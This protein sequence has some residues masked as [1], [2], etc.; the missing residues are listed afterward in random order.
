M[1]FKFAAALAALTLTT[2][3]WAGTAGAQ[4]F[5]DFM[6][7]CGSTDVDATAVRKAAEGLGWIALPDS[8]VKTFKPDADADTP[9]VPVFMMAAPGDEVG[10]LAYATAAMPLGE[11]TFPAETCMLI[12]E[13]VAQTAAHAGL[14]SLN[15]AVL[16]DDED[17]E[18][19]YMAFSRTA[20]GVRDEGA[21]D[22]ASDEDVAAV[23][24]DRPVFLMGYIPGQQT[25]LIKARI[26]DGG[27]T[28]GAH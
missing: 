24:R 4:S 22:E 12:T 9:F 5:D 15:L 26:R 25:I 18:G 8:L 3:G 23:L 7:M 11:Q 27:A 2:A 21:L 16:R 10:L 14:E 1:T 13:S 19:A 20:A 28:A 17:E 6:T